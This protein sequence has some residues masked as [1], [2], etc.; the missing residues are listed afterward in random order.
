MAKTAAR[1]SEEDEPAPPSQSDG[2]LHALPRRK[3]APAP[4]D[5]AVE[6]FV[7]ET[8]SQPKPA[9]PPPAPQQVRKRGSRRRILLIAGPV[10]VLVGTL[11]F[12]L[13]GG[14]WVSTDD[15]YVKADIVSVATD[16]SGMVA[17]VDVHNDQ[18]VKAGDVLFRLDD[19]PYRI[20]LEGAKAQLGTTANQIDALKAQYRQQ[21]AAVQNAQTDVAY[22]QLGIQRQTE[23]ASRAVAS[24][25]TLDQARHD[26]RSAQDRM[27]MAQRQADSVLAQ[28][29]G[30]ANKPT[31]ENPQ[32]LQAKA[33]VDKAER[34]LRRAIARA[35][36]DGIVTNVDTLQPGNYLQA[37]QPGM[38][39]VASDHVWV[40]ANLKETDLTY[41]RPGDPAEISVDAY[42][43]AEWKASVAT[44]SP[45]TG[46]QFSVL[47]A[48]NSSG[49]W[50]KVVQRLPVR[51]KVETNDKAPPLRAGM[52][53]VVDID[54]GHTRT[55]SG[56]FASL[57]GII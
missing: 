31:Q 45:A 13:G 47:P 57:R 49:N 25:A 53:V 35:P 6:A 16:V 30:D 12:Y 10:A 54:T 11:Y 46:A 36:V 44:I 23:L 15:S 43:G 17:K 33:Q 48:Q 28:L 26:Y 51:L 41:L 22:Y 8:K 52:S 4:Q 42:P 29:G 9:A 5:N 21:L 32:Y 39:L 3:D 38:S 18:H 34:D 37:S 24:Q 20:A 1:R 50:V 19:E 40:E 56:L 27:A 55:L 2:K 14:R 7:P